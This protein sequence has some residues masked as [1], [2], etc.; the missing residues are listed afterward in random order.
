M[1]GTRDVFTY[2]HCHNCK[3]LYL[4]ELPDT[5]DRY[6]PNTY[7]SYNYERGNSLTEWIRQ[8]RDQFAVTNR[9]LNGRLLYAILP[10][11][12]M[13]LLHWSGKSDPELSILDVG[14]GNGQELR[15]LQRLG[16]SNLYGIDH[17]SNVIYWI[18]SHRV[19]PYIRGTCG[20]G[21]VSTI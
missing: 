15:N 8:T 3:C 20:N 1:L 9:G 5:M 11:A 21:P 4:N 18:S 12:A 19:F 13:R 10:V 17:L 6:Y 7:Y 14:C 2:I 16:F